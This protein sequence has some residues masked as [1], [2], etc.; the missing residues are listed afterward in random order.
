MLD[1]PS[2]VNEERMRFFDCL[3]PIFSLSGGPLKPG[4]LDFQNPLFDGWKVKQGWVCMEPCCLTLELWWLSLYQ[5]SL[6]FLSTRAFCT[7]TFWLLLH[8]KSLLIS[9]KWPILSTQNCI[10]YKQNFFSFLDLMFKNK[11]RSKNNIFL[12]VFFPH[13]NYTMKWL[14]S[15]LNWSLKDLFHIMV[16]SKRRIWPSRPNVRIHTYRTDRTADVFL[17]GILSAIG[18]F[19]KIKRNAFSYC[20]PPMGCLL[21]VQV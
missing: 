14:I 12:V 10:C 20:V 6:A 9:Y 19:H 1:L 5:S 8:M 17:G 11:R 2:H 3:W 13:D 21:F 7:R 15:S 4:V 18:L 16:A